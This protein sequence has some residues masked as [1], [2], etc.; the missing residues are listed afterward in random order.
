MSPSSDPSRKPAL[1]AQILEHFEDK[2]LAS[3][4]FRTLASALGVS[5]YA[6]VYHFG[7]R[8]QLLSE[9]A[10]VIA[11]K[12]KSA[13]DPYLRDAPSLDTLMKQLWASFEWMLDP[14]NLHL[15]R[16]E[17]EAGTLEA[18]EAPARP[19]MPGVYAFWLDGTE[20]VLL[21]LGLGA[22]DAALESRILNNLF[23]GFQYD[24]VVNGDLGA[25]RTA[26]DRSMRGYREHL[27]SLLA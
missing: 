4:S 27:A 26:F 12:Q 16:L 23:Y 15:Q 6:L 22:E 7:T 11:E 21:D 3:L 2:P 19:H 14:D 17:F 24:I 25:A 8:E 18:V 10:R 20:R 1:L 13:E 9:I 5:T